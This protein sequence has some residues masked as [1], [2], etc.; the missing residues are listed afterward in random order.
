MLSLSI[1]DAADFVYSRTYDE[2]AGGVVS[3][4]SYCTALYCTELM[5]RHDVLF[6]TLCAAGVGRGRRSELCCDDAIG[7]LVYCSASR[8]VLYCLYC[9]IPLC[10][11]CTVSYRSVL[12]VLYHTTLYCLYGIVLLCTIC[13]VSYRFVLFV[14]CRTALFCR[15]V[16][17][18][19]TRCC[20]AAPRASSTTRCRSY[21]G[22]CAECVGTALYCCA[23]ALAYCLILMYSL[24]ANLDVPPLGHPLMYCLLATPDVPP[25]ACMSSGTAP[26]ELLTRTGLRPGRL[27][28]TFR[29]LAV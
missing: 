13:T 10:T 2:A 12:F 20:L 22:E 9:I 23:S 28:L 1:G 24:S 6:C 11:V 26:E 15:C 7:L 29:Q 19:A 21:T 5:M 3:Q 17:S 16:W 8:S 14:L 18:R 27:N 25:Y 4:W